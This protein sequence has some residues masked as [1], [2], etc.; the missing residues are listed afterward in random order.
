[1]SGETSLRTG[2]R[3]LASSLKGGILPLLL[4]AGAI[5][6][7]FPLEDLTKGFIA[8]L[9]LLGM[10]AVRVP[11]GI[12]LLTSGSLGIIAVSG[13]SVFV[14]SVGTIP[15]REVTSWQL[16]VLP[17]FVLMGLVLGSSGAAD[18][19]YAA[20][21]ATFSW[22]PGG[23]AVTTNFAGAILAS[24]SGST[25]GITYALARIGIPQMMR[26]GYDRRM[27]VGA[28]LM[29]GTGGQL[30][31]PSVL[32]VVFAGLA[33]VPVGQQLLA[34]LVPGVILALLYGVLIVGIAIWRP[35]LAPRPDTESITLLDRLRVFTIALP[36][37]ILVVVVLGGLFLG[38]F[39]ATEAASYGALGAI[40]VGVL[41]A[42]V[43]KLW[44][45]TREA[46][47]GAAVATASIMFLIV[48]A[49]FYA[50]MLAVSGVGLAFGD[51]VGGLNVSTWVF[52]LMLAVFY[53]GLG[54]FMDPLTMMLLTVPILL[55]VLGNYGLSALWLGVFVVLLGE[56]GMLTPPVGILSFVVH[57]IVQSPDIRDEFGDI[58]LED[59]F[60]GAFWFL[61]AALMVVLLLMFL[62]E[63]VEWLP[64]RA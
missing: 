60:A 32:M 8:T 26:A 11:V 55:P 37:P 52:V 56:I 39:T 48:G 51:L 4:V 40:I 25:L 29:A 27:A 18:R 14:S 45:M 9:V 22:L 24:V 16:A 28:V 12:A 17:M 61:P 19:I 50:R 15:F 6:M 38:A 2:E 34:G 53:L 63:L 54:T 44:S 49:A 7:F 23:L 33:G 46:A 13:W 62:P 47:I 42:G 1:M 21:N 3:V 57:R 59:V 5:A 64:A 10:I 58:R 43:G 41:Y 36:V 30:I 20:S 31:P 35:S